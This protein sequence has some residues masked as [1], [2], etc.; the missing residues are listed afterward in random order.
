M[1]AHLR[2]AVWLAIRMQST[3]S[4]RTLRLNN[5]ARR[6]HSLKLVKINATYENIVGYTY[7]HEYGPPAVELSHPL[8]GLFQVGE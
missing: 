5:Q 8:C 6:A 1:P 2:K 4:S 7:N 3:K